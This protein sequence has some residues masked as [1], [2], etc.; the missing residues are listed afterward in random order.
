[1]WQLIMVARFALKCGKGITKQRTCQDIIMQFN[2]VHDHFLT[3]VIQG[4]YQVEK[5][6]EPKTKSNP[7]NPQTRLCSISVT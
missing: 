5:K 2:H 7:F 6:K 1:M 4:V 3:P